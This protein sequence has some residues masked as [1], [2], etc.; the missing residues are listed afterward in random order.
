MKE[1]LDKKFILLI[2]RLLEDEKIRSVNDFAH[3]IDQ[4]PAAINK[5]KNGTRSPS[6]AMV[7]NAIRVFELN[8]NFF[9]YENCDYMYVSDSD[10][11]L[12][13]KKILE[14][15]EMRELEWKKYAD[16]TDKLNR[17]LHKTIGLFVEEIDRLKEKIANLEERKQVS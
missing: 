11:M 7:I 4:E 16:D 1:I 5:V 17:D 9:Y 2:N 3:K 14:Q 13:E 6:P 8:A 12:L 15:I 10:E